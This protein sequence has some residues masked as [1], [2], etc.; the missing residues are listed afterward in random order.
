MKILIAYFSRTGNTE[1]MARE[2]EKIL[3][4]RGHTVSFEII[5]PSIY[6]S[7]LREALRDFP[8]VPAIALAIFLPVWRRH[9]FRTYNQVEEDIQALAYPNVSEF[10]IVCIGTPKWGHISYPV[11][12]YMQIVR[13]LRGKKTGVFATFA[14]PPLK[15][16]EI[17]LLFEPMKIFLTRM[18]SRVIATAGISTGFHEVGLMPL[19]NLISKLRFRKPIKDFKIESEYGQKM[20][21]DFCDSIENQKNKGEYH[22]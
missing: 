7:I 3:L 10:D 9:Y 11:A 15:I 1:I 20:I 13:G 22:A 14:G 18:G 2:I 19:F 21:K 16:F 8:R 6:Y 17:E 12:R 4:Q 5:K